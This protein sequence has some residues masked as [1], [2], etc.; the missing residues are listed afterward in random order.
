MVVCSPRSPWDRRPWRRPRLRAAD[1]ASRPRSPTP[2][3]RRARRLPQR[4]YGDG[5]C[6]RVR[7][8]ARFAD[9]EHLP[10]RAPPPTS[11]DLPGAGAER[12]EHR[13]T[14]PGLQLRAGDVELGAES[15]SADDFAWLPASAPAAAAHRR[16]PRSR[17][18]API[19]CC[20][21]APGMSVASTEASPARWPVRTSLALSTVPVGSACVASRPGSACCSPH[22][23]RDSRSARA[24]R[25]RSPRAAAARARAARR[26][27]RPAPAGTAPAGAPSAPR[28][29][30]SLDARTD[31][32]WDGGASG[33]VSLHRPIP[34][35]RH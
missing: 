11:A 28:R 22:T 34:S 6:A 4:R 12:G 2:A 1:R 18:A 15:T 16:A 7:V 21:R 10:G 20:A 31:E 26:R 30:R 33:E 17:G 24:V 23:P 8:R 3:R 29:C 5:R 13:H 32:T 9:R 25:A 14:I 27:P 35:T 19:T